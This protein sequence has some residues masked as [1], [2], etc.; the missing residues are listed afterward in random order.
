MRSL[1]QAVVLATLSAATALIPSLA[2]AQDAGLASMHELRREGGRVCM[3]DHFHYGTGNGSSKKA[4]LADAIGSWQSFTD[5]EYGPAWA[6]WNR[7]AS[8]QVK[9]GSAASGFSADVSSRPCR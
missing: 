8:K 6:R 4:A 7:S 3:S 1:T 2:S 9:Y 5:F